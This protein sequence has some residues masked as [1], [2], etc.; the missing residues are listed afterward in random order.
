[1]CFL[2]VP[3]VV[4]T[5]LACTHLRFHCEHSPVS[6]SVSNGTLNC[7]NYN[8]LLEDETRG[9]QT[10]LAT[11]KHVLFGPHN[12]VKRNLRGAWVVQVAKRLTLDLGSGHV[13]M[14]HE[15]KPCIRLCTD[16]TEPLWD[17]VSPS[18]CSSPACVH[19]LNVNK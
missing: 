11:Q 14:V 10:D 2:Q 6:G 3:Q 15:F 12:V 18:L 16:G 7:R 4:P 19:S 13:L 1:M 9:L 5:R 8:I 17:S